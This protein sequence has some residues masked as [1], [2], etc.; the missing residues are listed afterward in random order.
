MTW[1]RTIDMTHFEDLWI[2]CED[3]Q[4]EAAEPRDIPAMAEE[5]KMKIDLY[6]AITD[7]TKI[8]SEELRKMRTRIMGEILMTLAGLSFKDNV[9]VFEALAQ[10]LQFRTID[11][12]N[13]KHPV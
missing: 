11:H 1:I 5:L 2:A 10:A 6:K 8:P 13:D 7:K 12:L 9:N 4:K 3:F